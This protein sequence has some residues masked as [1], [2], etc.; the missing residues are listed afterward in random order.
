[1]LV[2]IS[3]DVARDLYAV[4]VRQARAEFAFALS[5]AGVVLVVVV[6]LVE[7]R[8]WNAVGTLVLFTG[9]GLWQTVTRWRGLKRHTPEEAGR[10]GLL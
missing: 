7:L 6:I 3:P 8:R 5:V 9:A 4:A 10:R 1:M 2:D